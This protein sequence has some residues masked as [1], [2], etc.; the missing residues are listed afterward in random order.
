ML[1]H[2]VEKR[3]YGKAGCLLALTPLEKLFIALANKRKAR[4]IRDQEIQLTLD[5]ACKIIVGNIAVGGTGKTPVI[6]T[7]VKL[8]KAKG[9]NVAVIS[10]GYGR[11]SSGLIDIS[12]NTAPSE[13][14]DEPLL[15]YNETNTPVIVSSDRSASAHYAIQQYGCDTLLFDDGMQDYSL[16]RDIE[17]AVVDGLR[18]FGNHHCLPVG[19]LREP[20]ERLSQV[21]YVLI[22]QGVCDASLNVEHDRCFSIAIAP[23][24]FRNLYNNEVKSLNDMSSSENLVAVS[25]IGN[26]QKFY[27]TL[28]TLDLKYVRDAYPD[29]HG[30][31]QSDLAKW[32]NHTVIMTG[33]DGIKCQAFGQKNWW[34]LDINMNIPESFLL[35]LEK[36]ILTIKEQRAKQ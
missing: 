3:W 11:S 1:K 8:L 12:S 9:H 7:L 31:K 30:F 32:D 33:K 28:D 19:P 16:P 35:E 2:F 24:Q 34:V 36:A 23:T 21:D 10:K 20:I 22:N 27:S 5:R 4:S 18:G 14:G 13:S 29:H 26:P 6:I 17:I 25:G 15:I